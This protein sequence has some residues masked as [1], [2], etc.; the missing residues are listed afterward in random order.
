MESYELDNTEKY[1]LRLCN[2]LPDY[3]YSGGPRVVMATL[4]SFGLVREMG[5]MRYELTEE[6]ER[7]LP[8]CQLPQDYIN[9]IAVDVP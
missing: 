5:N 3:Q 2:E 1:F 7:V 9:E 4:F 6:G 8:S